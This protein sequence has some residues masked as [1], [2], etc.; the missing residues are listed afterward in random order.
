M[1][2]NATNQEL[3][4][5]RRQFGSPFADYNG[6]SGS[7]IAANLPP[8]QSCK[9]SALGVALVLVPT[10]PGDGIRRKILVGDFAQSHERPVA[11]LGIRVRIGNQVNKAR[12]ETEALL[13]LKKSA[14]GNAATCA[15]ADGK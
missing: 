14:V 8:L 7:V 3:R 13:T 9:L 4:L 6:G 12:N 10:S 5:D 1:S 2:G 11:H 15:I